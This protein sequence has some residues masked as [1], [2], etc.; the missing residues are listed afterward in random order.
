M[1]IPTSPNNSAEQSG[2]RGLRIRHGSLTV[3][4]LA[5]FVLAGVLVSAL[6]N[7]GTASA[8]GGNYQLWWPVS[9][10]ITSYCGEQRSYET[11]QGTDISV[12]VGTPVH[13]AYDGTVHN[14]KDGTWGGGGNVV[15]IDH[16]N[17][18]VTFYMHLSQFLVADGA[19][20]SRG[21]TVA[22]S[23]NT[24]NSTGPHVH[25]QINLNGAQPPYQ[26]TG[27]PTRGSVTQDTLVPMNVN[28]PAPG[29]TTTNRIGILSTGNSG[30]LYV[31]DGGLNGGWSEPPQS[32]HVTEMSMSGSRIGIA[33]TNGTCWARDDLT[34]PWSEVADGCLNI[35][36]TPTRIG[37]L[38]AP[39]G[40]T[41][42][43]LYVRDGAVNQGLN[44]NFTLP[45]QSDHITE[46]SL[47]GSRIG[48]A[49]TNGTCWARQDLTSLWTEEADG[50]TNIQVLGQ[51]I[52]ILSTGNSG[53]L[54][55]K[56]G[57]I[58]TGGVNTGFVEPAG[59]DHLTAFGLAAYQQ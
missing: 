40:S 51:R 58:D 41:Y 46:F 37:I 57:A 50:C 11:H 44:A 23:G 14:H 28:L 48:I 54:F 21:N 31:Q 47:D 17:G 16:P 15:E 29:P 30:T 7:A 24:G 35:Q 9:G 33:T 20:V 53:T 56:D 6:G 12:P 43:T 52:G 42:G 10:Q 18:Y 26:C 49:T 2:R 19:H 55:V 36:V 1:S 5:A 4:V 22:L 39:L 25:F 27:L 38:S 3:A 13:A 34:S 59:A 32:D 45:P 8:A